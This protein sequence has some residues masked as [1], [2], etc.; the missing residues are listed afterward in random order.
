[1]FMYCYQ[2]KSGTKSELA[3]FSCSDFAR[4]PAPP[5]RRCLL[6]L[7]RQLL[8]TP[9]PDHPPS[10]LFCA[11]GPARLLMSD[12]VFDLG[13]RGGGAVYGLGLDKGDQF[14]L[15]GSQDGL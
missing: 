7:R 5:P 8:R 6:A 9:E 13:G 3:P 4:Y 10:T 2:S 14:G 12:D 11:G 1:M 15:G